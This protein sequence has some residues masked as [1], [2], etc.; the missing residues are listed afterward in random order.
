[1]KVMKFNII[2]LAAILATFGI[3]GTAQALHDGGVARCEACHTMHNSLGGQSM[4]G[5]NG[6]GGSL[7]KGSDQSS[8]CLNCHNGGGNGYHVNSTDGSNFTGGGDFY[9]L[10]KT[11][12][13]VSRGTTVSSMGDEHGHNI[14]AADYGRTVDA[15]LT[16]APG[17]TYNAGSL[18]CTSCH[19]PHGNKN[20]GGAITASGSYGADPTTAVVGNYRLLG[21]TGYAAGSGVTFTNGVPV[22]R[23]HSSGAETN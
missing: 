22:A 12:T 11:F 10:S 14:V 15:T 6:V 4:A 13:W 16:V 17:G 5:V 23:A 19:D 2:A 8:T 3:R 7:T 18:G 20:S 9:W 21:D 1:M